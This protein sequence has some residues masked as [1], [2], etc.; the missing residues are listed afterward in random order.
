MIPQSRERCTERAFLFG[1]RALE[2]SALSLPWLAGRPPLQHRQS[3]ALHRANAWTEGVHE[4]LRARTNGAM[5][6]AP[7]VIRHSGFVIP[8]APPFAH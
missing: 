2:G 1:S 7:L 6:R 8:F 3:N 5:E 4:N